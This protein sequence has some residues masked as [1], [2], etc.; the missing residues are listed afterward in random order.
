MREIAGIS[1]RVLV[2]LAIVV[3]FF[4]RLDMATSILWLGGFV[5]FA[6]SFVRLVHEL[7]SYRGGVGA[8]LVESHMLEGTDAA[9]D[10]GR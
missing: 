3:L 5:V 2:T 6:W 4:V 8:K 9:V 1:G 10:A 7:F